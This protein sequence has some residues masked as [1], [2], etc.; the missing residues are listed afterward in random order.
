MYLL[1]FTSTYFL[2]P[3]DMASKLKREV[4]GSYSENELNE[5]INAEHM[6]MKPRAASEFYDIPKSTLSDKVVIGQ[7]Q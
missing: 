5:A 7:W 3:A 4:K 1:P 2:L 6:G